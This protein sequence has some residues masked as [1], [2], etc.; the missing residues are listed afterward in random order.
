[1]Y[2]PEFV[3]YF[4]NTWASIIAL[5]TGAILSLIK[6]DVKFNN[7]VGHFIQYIM[8][9]L[10]RLLLKITLQPVESWFGTLKHKN[11]DKRRHRREDEAEK[12]DGDVMSRWS[13]HRF[14]EKIRPIYKYCLKSVKKLQ[15]IT[16]CMIF[17]QNGPRHFH[18]Q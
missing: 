14:I 11:M 10:Y 17:I 9:F 15:L 12:D 3:I 16:N 13:Y 8:F 18:D 2:F 5:W 4:I 1:M 6:T 7:Q